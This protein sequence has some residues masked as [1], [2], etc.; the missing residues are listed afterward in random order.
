MLL[1]SERAPADKLAIFPFGAM[2]IK[3]SARTRF[4]SEAILI[5]SSFDLSGDQCLRQLIRRCGRYC[6]GQYRP[7][8]VRRSSAASSSLF[9]DCNLANHGFGVSLGLV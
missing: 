8:F 6:G 1:T 9:D 7:D 3:S 5:F 4:S 2:V